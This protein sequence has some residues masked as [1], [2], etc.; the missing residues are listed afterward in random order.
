MV[1]GAIATNSFSAGSD[2]VRQRALTAELRALDARARSFA[3]SEGPVELSVRANEV[4]I[5]RSRADSGKILVRVFLPATAR[6]AVTTSANADTPG[7][8]FFDRLGQ[9]VDYQVIVALGARQSCDR[10]HGLTGWIEEV[11]PHGEN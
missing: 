2:E 11:F 8:V 1:A 5:E 3:R 9:S 4:T 7:T 6:V 10:V